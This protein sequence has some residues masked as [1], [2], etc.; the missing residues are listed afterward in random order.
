VAKLLI[1][2]GAPLEARNEFGNTPLWVA[3]MNRRTGEGAQVV[4]ALL[5]AGA[6][7]D[8]TNDTGLSVRDLADRMGEELPG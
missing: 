7:V 3:M 8:A 6:S 4:T 5:S 1:E 2:A